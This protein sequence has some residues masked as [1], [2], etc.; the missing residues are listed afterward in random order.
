MRK[1]LREPEVKARTGTSR[2]TRWRGA[3]NRTFPAPVQLGPNSVGWYEDDIDE[4]LANRPTVTWASKP[5]TPQ[6]A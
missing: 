5:A 4:W 2:V 3:R 6:A 1:I